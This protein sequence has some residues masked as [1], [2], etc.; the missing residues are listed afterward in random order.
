MKKHRTHRGIS[1]FFSSSQAFFRKS[2][3]TALY[4]SPRVPQGPKVKFLVQLTIISLDNPPTTNRKT[5]MATNPAYYP[6]SQ[7]QVTSL[8]DSPG[9][10]I[11]KAAG[12]FV[13]RHY[14]WSSLYFIGMLVVAFAK[15]Y[16]VDGKTTRQFQ[17]VPSPSQQTNPPFFSLRPSPFSPQTNTNH[18]PPPPL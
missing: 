7:R 1:I 16:A 12:G 5:K 14:V 11:A 13:R 6:G 17:R 18:L 8:D 10:Y 4:S 9:L 15:G 2:F 3:P